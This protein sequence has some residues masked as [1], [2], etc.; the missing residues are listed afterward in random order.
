LPENLL[1]VACST[2]KSDN[3]EMP[4]HDN[5]AMAFPFMLNGLRAGR[6]KSALT[7]NEGWDS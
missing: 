5:N 7:A 3:Q 2:K 4:L 6:Y 1:S